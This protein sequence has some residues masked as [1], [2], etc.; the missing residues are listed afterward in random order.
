MKQE[1]IVAL[2]PRNVAAAAW[3]FFFRSFFYT[4]RTRTTHAN[5]STCGYANARAYTCVR[6]FRCTSV[7]RRVQM[8]PFERCLRAPKSNY[9]A[10]D[11]A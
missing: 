6:A 5:E 11:R 8:L 2:D 7:P 3:F 10:R 4:F 9:S 1:A